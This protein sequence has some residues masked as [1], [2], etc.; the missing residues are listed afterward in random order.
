MILF[1]RLLLLIIIFSTSL[2][3]ATL[4][5]ANNSDSGIGTFRK[6]TLDAHANSDLSNTISIPTAISLIS[7][8]DTPISIVDKELVLEISANSQLTIQGFLDGSGSLKKS[9]RGTLVLTKTNSYSGG[10]TVSSGILQGTTISLQGAINNNA[11]VIFNQTRTGTYAGVMSGFGSL[12]KQNTGTLILSGTNTYSG[13]T[14]LSGG[15]LS[16][17]SDT[18]LGNAARTLTFNGGTL[19][20]TAGFTSSRAV[21]L[22]GD[23]TVE[24]SG[25]PLTMSGVV[26]GSGA[27]T[28]RGTGTLTL[29]AAN[30]YS[31]GTTVSSGI[32]QGTATSLQGSIT[33]NASVI[34]NQTT[35]GT[36]SGVMSGSGSLTKQNTGTLVLSGANTY[37]GG[38]GVTAGILQGTTT[39]LQGSITNNSSVIFNQTTTGTYAGVMSGS[40]SLTK[41]NTGTLILSG[42]NTYRGGT[43]VAAGILQGTTRSLQGAIT[44]NSS[45][46]FDQ[47]TDGTYSGVITGSGSL[48]K[49]NT[50]T[51]VLSGT[52]TYSGGTTF[53]GGPLSI[54]ADNNLGNGSGTLTFNKGTLL[55]TAG[56]NSSRSITLTGAGTVDVS[57]DPVSLLGVITGSGSFTKRGTG[58]LV[59]SGANT[60]SGGTAFTGGRLSI[61]ADNNLGASAGTLTFNEGTLLTTAGFNSSR[62]VTLT[63]AGT[64][65][66]SADPVSLLGV[67]TGSGSF[68]KRGTGTLILSAANTYSGGTAFTGGRLSIAADNNLGASVGTLTFNEGTLLITAGLT[69]SRSILL[70]GAGTIEV[71]AAP[72]ALVGVISGSGSL[73]KNGNSTLV[74]AGANTYSGG[75]TVNAGVLGGASTSLQGA[76]TNNSSVIF[77]QPTTGTYSGVMSG[78]GSLIKQNT[79]TLILSGANTYSGGTTISG[80]SLSIAS[81]NN[82]GNGSGDLT[83]NG[84]SL[85]ST[86]GFTSSRNILLTGAG[87]IEVNGSSIAMLG[88]VSGSGTLTKRGSGTLSLKGE[89]TYS[90]GTTLSKGN[91]SISSDNNLGNRSGSLTFNGGTLLLTAGLSSSR[92]VLLTGPGTIEVSAAPV[93]LLG[94]I[95][96][97]GTLTKRGSGTLSLKGSNTYSGGTVVSSG[98]LQGTST[99]LQ[100]AITNNSS[101]V[102]NQSTT[103]SCSGVISGSGSLT[104]Q[105]T[106]TL[107]LSGANTYRGGTTVSGGTLSIASNNNL[108]NGLGSLTFNEGTLLSTAGFTSSRSVLLTGPGTIEVSGSPLTMSGVVTGSGDLSKSGSGTLI[109]SGEN[110]YRGGTTVSGGRLSISSNN[111]LGIEAGS[112]TLN[113]GTLLLT[114]GLTSSR[115]VLLTGPGT[116]DVSAAP[117][118]LLG[119]I[120]DSGTLTK[121]GNGTLILSGTNTYSGGTIVAAGT[122]QGT[123]T[124]LQK[125]ITNNSSVIFNQT[126]SGSYSGVMSGSGSL[127]KQ[128]TGTLILSGANTYRG[129]TTFAGGTLSIAANT[130][131]GNGSGS[132]TFNEGTLLSTA[133]FISSRAVLLT[134]NGT[135]EVSGSPLTMSGVVTGS[136]ALSKRGSGTL[137]LSGA[138]T[139]SGGTTVSGGRL[140]V[141]SNNN[142]GSES[143]SL[144]FN[145]GTLLVTAGLTSSRTVLLTGNGT[146]DVSADPV[147]LLGVISD[148]GTLTK[149][150]NGT[151]ILSG[152]NTY[153]GGT[154]V[155]DGILQGTT[156]SLQGAIT[157]NSSVVFNQA[158]TGTYAG[159]MSGS[160]SLSKQNTGTTILTGANT[161]RGGTVVTAGIL[162]GTTTSLQGAITNNSSVI[163]N[164][165]T[166]GTY[167]GVISGS[168]SLSKQNTGTTI[169]TGIHT[170]TGGTTFSGGKLSI[171]ADNNLGNS[172]GI[173]TF[174]GGTLLT[175]A[176]FTSSRDVVL[177]GAGTIEVSTDSLLL[178][179]VVNGSGNLRK[180][181]AGR[182]TL[183]GENTYSGGTIVSSG[184]LQG[185]TTS[186]QGAITNNSSVVFNQTSTG[187]YSGVMSGSGSLT[188]YNT[189]TLILSGANTYSGGTVVTSGVLQGTTTSLQGAIN[190]NSSVVFNQTTTGTYSGVM[191]GSGSLTKHNTGTLILSGSNTYSGG[192]TCSGGI[193]NISTDNNLG[194]GSGTLTFNEGTL[195]TTAGFTSS[196]AVI[197]TGNG[198]IEVSG[199]SLTLSGVVRGSGALTKTGTCTLVLSGANTYTGG[200]TVSEGVLQGTTTS[201]QKA[202]TNNSSVIFDQTITGTYSGVMSGSGSLTKQNTGTTVLT[203]VNTYTGGTTVTAGVL[204]GTTTSLQGSI[205][206]N[207]SVI[208]DQ[209]ITGTYSGIMSG[210]GSLIKRNT[211]T[212]V[213]T[214]VNTYTG[215]TTLSGGIL[216]ISADNNLGPIKGALTFNEG[217]LLTTEGFTSTR[218]VL[219][220]GNGTIEVSGSPLTLSGAVSGSGTLIKTG[221]GTLTLSG[222]KTYTGGTTVT[223]GVLQ[224]TTLS[225]QRDLTNNS[226]VVFNQVQNGTYSGTISGSGSLTKTG[227]GTLTITGANTFE[228]MTHIQKGSL[229]IR[230]S[231]TSPVTVYPLATLRGTGT[232]GTLKNNGTV[233]PGASIGTL[234]INGDYTQEAAGS[235]VIEISAKDTTSDLLLVTGTAHLDGN[236]KLNPLPGMY[237]EGTTFTFLKADTIHGTFNQLIETHPED[238]NL[239]YSTNFV[240]LMIPFTK[241]IL[242]VPLDQLKKNAKRVAQHIFSHYSDHSDEFFAILT[243]LTSVSPAEFPNSLLQLSPKRFEGLALSS[244]QTHACVGQSMNRISDAYQTYYTT[245]N[246]QPCKDSASPSNYSV[247]INSF[248]CY[249][250]HDQVQELFA[251]NNKTYG[252]TTGL[253]TR[254]SEH[255]VLSTGAG[256]THSN[257]YWY[258]NQGNANI[259]SVHLSPSLGYIGKCGYA[260][261]VLLG[262]RSFYKA[263]RKIHFADV[264]GKLHNHHK[265]YDLLAGFKGGLKLKCPESFQK[266]LFLFPIVNIDYLNIFENKYKESGAGNLNLAV[267]SIQSA[268]LRPE[269][270]LKLSKELNTP[271]VFSAPSIYVGLVKNI[272]LKNERYIAQFYKQ[273]SLPKYF[274]QTSYHKSTKQLVLGAEVL[275]ITYEDNFSL[276][277]DYEAN[278]G[279]HSKVQKGNLNFSWKF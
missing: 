223:E 167:A 209:T 28:K 32:L 265:S 252:F 211:G 201:L 140:S 89:N 83:L 17:S 194:N 165:A 63:G 217:T 106:G 189:K 84:G 79:G 230:G 186:L 70:T 139:Y 27:L 127:T 264:K 51:V 269:L 62:S 205:I 101:V 34:F 102:F 261:V 234:T 4:Q 266:N 146:V 254:L 255:L 262:S 257:L 157:N 20:S 44:N 198:T 206:N 40:G 231:L 185:T 256:Y 138:N 23:G 196:R 181:G 228:T 170:Y 158:I 109:L 222:A 244:L 160:G 164:Q 220:T 49:R 225:L 116:V 246:C 3:A 161:Y 155:S 132:L 2:Q 6:A 7:L 24:V 152:T 48:T 66:V 95:S 69:S 74:L 145:E 268:F 9:G 182:L 210:S 117:V 271:T 120:S 190:N 154:I 113:G 259:Q 137:I 208:F 200:T 88:I 202:I 207:S 224:G 71:N 263:D 188:T 14:T 121:M 87:T 197:L 159:I 12:T 100:G 125:A 59:L 240:E 11:S 41:Q 52:N 149:M 30:T 248:G 90:G 55:S 192:T 237:T 195:L 19:L 10:T 221:T 148:S 235:L 187:T 97:S 37:S 162:Q 76:I 31:G 42:A 107:I 93:S 114:A 251:F 212:T 180:S 15:T 104:K 134:G 278:L 144:T 227:L 110:T 72:V 56:F 166:T 58:T 75:T 216:S 275:L 80:G 92:N 172:S 86:A 191:S 112:L 258:E 45:V 273:A 105:N 64:V 16:I 118:S 163:F 33:N 126:T 245:P 21:I 25:S 243:A 115:N 183:S 67:I 253:S 250:K 267:K 77:N 50:G 124:S 232:V 204:Q 143:G 150:G 35:T 123:T 214:G 18:N 68:T 8:S 46:I 272:P 128:N 242:P 147:S 274:T 277:V 229:D 131:L 203:G 241:A 99:S 65:D 238:F 133:G 1:Q 60:Y 29:S 171:S 236:I 85:L 5:V 276:K 135:I 94:V 22:T 193:L 53:I 247:W 119:V 270:K 173:L 184:I 43:V 38:T 239:N 61:A 153:S 122:L 91:L 142:L 57:A 108:G 136:G 215:G 233:I 218:P 176:G 179:G 98:I 39:S 249:Y 54:A 26:Y 13:G 96:G 219:L 73:T 111:H 175:T 82:L 36:Y 103:G 129:G 141:A 279:K 78:S 213:L 260:G 130:N 81:N 226:S 169:L 151:L 199:D 177:T 178:S 168:G 47:T 156:T 174:N